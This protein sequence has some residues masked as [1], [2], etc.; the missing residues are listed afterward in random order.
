MVDVERKPKD[1]ERPVVAETVVDLPETIIDDDLR[2]IMV[3]GNITFDSNAA[4]LGEG[5][6]AACAS[7]ETFT[8]HA[9]EVIG[10][11]SQGMVV[12]A[13]DSSGADYAAKISYPI[14]TARDRRNRKAVLESLVSLMDEHPL[15]RNHF[16]Q[17]HLMPLYA[18][19]KIAGPAGSGSPEYNVAI[20]ALCDSSLGD[21]HGCSYEEIRRTVLPQTA[22]GL[23]ALHAQGIVHRDIKPKNLYMLDGSIVLG[24]YGISSLL[25]EGKDTGA[26]VF[27]KRTPGYSPHSSVVQRE[28][29]WYALGYTIW[30]L[31][32]HGEHPHQA[33][34]DAGDL[35]AVLAGKRPVEFIPNDPDEST[36]GDLI[37]GLTLEAPRG[38][39]G[40]QDIQEWLD[41]PASFRFESP[42]DVAES[43]KTYQFRGH[44]Y[45]DN[46]ELADAMAE[47]WS[48][49]SEHI[50]SE[51]LEDFLK[52]SGQ[53]DLA[54]RAHRALG[55]AQEW[56]DADFGI[57]SV[58]TVLKGSAEEFVWKGQWHR[59]AGI[60]D[61]S[62]ARLT[63]DPYVI[64]EYASDPE[65]VRELLRFFLVAYAGEQAFA[66]NEAVVRAA[67]AGIPGI[68]GSDIILRVDSLLVMFEELCT[69]KVPVRGFF[70]E[71]GPSGDS[72]WIRQHIGSYS[73]TTED[74]KRAISAVRNVR[75]PSPESESIERARAALRTLDSCVE[76]LAVLLPTNPYIKMLGL[77]QEASV[78]IKTDVAYRV[79]TAFGERCTIGYATLIVPP[80]DRDDVCD[81]AALRG[82]AVSEARE[83]ARR[84]RGSAEASGSSRVAGHSKTWHVIL[85]AC[86]LAVLLF[87]WNSFGDLK[88]DYL[89]AFETYAPAM[90]EAGGFVPDAW[91]DKTASTS[92]VPVTSEAG[93]QAAATYELAPAA[94]P[95]EGYVAEETASESVVSEAVDEPAAVP[96]NSCTFGLDVA[97]FGFTVAALCV[98]LT[99]ILELVPVMFSSSIRN[100]RLRNAEKLES[101]ASK[102]EGMTLVHS[103][104]MLLS[105]SRMA[106]G[107][108]I[109]S[110][111][112][113]LDPDRYPVWKAAQWAARC[114]KLAIVLLIAGIVLATVT[115][116]PLGLGHLTAA[117]LQSLQ[118]GEI[119]FGQGSLLFTL[120]VI[121][122]I[123]F[124]V[125]GLRPN[126]LV[127]VF[128]SLPLPFF[129]WFSVG[130]MFG[131]LQMGL[132]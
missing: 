129:V 15:G 100:R 110:V 128:L 89:T 25:D 66:R 41:D 126:M 78:T 120:A 75:I 1:E 42:F 112:P 35:S 61:E 13:T 18:Y 101:D 121:Y 22:D 99:R 118:P 19:G 71:Y 69:N 115:W 7:S 132:L 6:M 52:S 81:F 12:R 125:G 48:D 54:V 91:F 79:A 124:R 5:R 103:V 23:R 74:A 47:H 40:Y 58:I 93:A 116:V 21:G 107:R 45:S 36:L 88:Q 86:T 97:L 114:Y 95:P 26:T 16:K 94:S 72:V 90:E 109:L 85:M 82:S 62:F 119:L 80:A 84:I 37:Y 20:M 27:D 67:Y 117:Q 108:A 46:G 39:L 9:D 70:I 127:V 57:A 104:E 24:D 106:S 92:E 111:Q 64:Y 68:G 63:S 8:I 43:A 4:S 33:L 51:T 123:V 65:K 105:D 32:N 56:G 34:I 2:P 31:Y 17:T 14:A 28:N 11:G 122:A 131:F 73:G 76:S 96:L 38:R 10:A 59:R 83:T 44:A 29:D 55:E 49:A 30:T 113:S 102:L 60:A 53:Q 130:S 77:G 87:V 3:S 50:Q 98:L